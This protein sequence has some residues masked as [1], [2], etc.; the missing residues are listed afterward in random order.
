MEK[1]ILDNTSLSS[2]LILNLQNS[3]KSRLLEFL[4][5]ALTTLWSLLLINISLHTYHKHPRYELIQSSIQV[6]LH[7]SQTIGLEEGTNLGSSTTYSEF[8]QST[9]SSLSH[10]IL[11]Y[12]LNVWQSI[13]TLGAPL[14]KIKLWHTITF[15]HR[16]FNLVCHTQYRLLFKYINSNIGMQVKTISIHLLR[17]RT[18]LI[19]SIITLW[20]T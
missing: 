1:K 3:C 12:S 11:I 19:K 16:I 2:Q 15:L 13:E 9:I 17:K 5:H 20:I 10:Y 18:T 14:C 6:Y 8:Q 7:L 4:S